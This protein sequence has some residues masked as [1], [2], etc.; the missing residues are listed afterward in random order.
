MVCLILFSA[1]RVQTHETDLIIVV[2]Y[3]CTE[4]MR[5]EGLYDDK[6]SFCTV[7]F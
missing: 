4:C 1:F 3:T 7:S 6:K 2:I 5:L